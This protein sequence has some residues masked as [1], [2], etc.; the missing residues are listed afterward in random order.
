[1]ATFHERVF[2]GVQP[3]DILTLSVVPLVIAVVALVACALPGRRAS[4][5]APIEALRR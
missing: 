3:T 2:S 1:M 4:R 5:I